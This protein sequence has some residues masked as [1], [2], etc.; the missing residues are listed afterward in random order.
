MTTEILRI[1]ALYR[2]KN[3]D[4]QKESLVS[5]GR[6]LSRNFVEVFSYK[7]LKIRV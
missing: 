6:S 1:I 4:P 2:S 7:R 3:C 5:D